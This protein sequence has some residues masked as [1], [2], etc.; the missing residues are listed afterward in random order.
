LR[1]CVSHR[2]PP[3]YN[4]GGW[5]PFMGPPPPT[6]PGASTKTKAKAKR[7]GWWVGKARAGGSRR[8]GRGHAAEARASR[9]ARD[10]KRAFPCPPCFPVLQASPALSPPLWGDRGGCESPRW[11]RV[12]WSHLYHLSK[13]RR[14]KTRAKRPATAPTARPYELARNQQPPAVRR[15]LVIWRVAARRAVATPHSAQHGQD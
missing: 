7:L 14:Q 4:R 3:L 1:F 12:C 9:A 8:V 6:P 11:W 2:T 10:Q 5:D 13:Q 15:P